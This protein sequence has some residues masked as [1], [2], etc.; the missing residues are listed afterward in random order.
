MK[1]ENELK[2]AADA[3]C[4]IDA[5]DARSHSY[6]YLKTIL[7]LRDRGLLKLFISRHSLYEI[8]KSQNAIDLANTCEI[9]PYHPIG[10]WGDQEIVKWG[11]LAGTWNDAK[12]N[13]TV[14]EDI[15]N[16]AKSGTD[17]RDRGA[18]IDALRAAVDV[19]MTSDRQLAGNGSA[20]RIAGKYGLKILTPKQFAEET[21]LISKFQIYSSVR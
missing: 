2:V 10:T 5:V 13:Q 8:Q 12:I 11:A 19:Y 3:N 4:F 15:Q 20:P 17:I 7:E 9:L 6:P 21:G 18:Y 1:K 14:Q 16:L